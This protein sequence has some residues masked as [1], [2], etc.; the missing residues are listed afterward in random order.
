MRCSA[1]PLAFLCPGSVRTDYGVLVDQHYDAADDGT[2]A[3]RLMA[4]WPDGDA[5]VEMVGELSEEGQILYY[6]AAKMWREEIAAWMPNS[7]AEVALQ[8]G[9]LTGHVDRIAIV[10][11]K[12]VVL[13]WK[14]GRKD[15]S[16]KHQG[17]GYALLVMRKHPEVEIVTVHFG[18]VREKAIENYTVSRA[19]AEEWDHQR[20]DRILGWEGVYTSGDHCTGCR[21]R[22]SCPGMMAIARSSVEMLTPGLPDLA[23]MSG[24]QLVEF[25]RR[26]K[27]LESVLK[28]ADEAERAEVDKR[29]DVFDDAG[30]VLHFVEENGQRDVDALKAWPVLTANLSDEELAPCL[31]VRLGEVEK[32]IAAKA[33]KGKGAAAKRELAEALGAAGA[34]TQ[35]KSRKLKLHRKD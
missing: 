14:T 15:S 24:P 12:A 10:G 9:E 29:G 6:T 3:H 2:D 23:L 18:W 4:S 20:R 32:T 1:L 30:N 19:R 8:T 17:F 11:A 5:P 22:V 26:R 16:H 21:R 28:L 35:P 34:V 13:D 7:I 27:V 33:G 31:K 25:H